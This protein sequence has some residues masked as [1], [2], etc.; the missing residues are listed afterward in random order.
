MRLL[1]SVM[2]SPWFHA[3]L[4]L[5]W[6]AVGAGLRL[7][8]LGSKAPWTDEF[9][10]IVFSLGHSFRTVP[11]D[12]AISLDVLLQPIRF[13][14]TTGIGDVIANLLTQSN[15]PPLYFVLAH[16]WMGLFPPEDGLVSMWVARSLPAL[17]GVLSIP[18]MFG[19]AYLAFRSRLVA[20][21]C[22]AMMAV[23]P[24]GI[25]LAQEA[26][27]Y[28]LAILFVIASLCCLIVTVQRLNHRSSIP[29]W[30]GVS[31]VVINT[32]GVATHYFFALTLCAEALMLLAM[33]WHQG[34]KGRWGAGELGSGGV[35]ERG[36]GGAREQRS[37]GAEERG[38][39]GDGE[40]SLISFPTKTK[41]FHS[42]ALSSKLLLQNQT[43][44]NPQ[45]NSRP[46]RRIY[47]V[48]AGT[49]AGSLVWLPIL[50]ANYDSDLTHWIYDGEPLKRWF[51]P[52]G[53]V[54]AWLITILISLPMEI[55][56]VSLGIAIASGVVTAIFLLWALPLLCS[57]LKLE[58][59]PPDIRLNIRVMRDFII[60]A[61]ALFF[62][63]TYTLGADL[64]LAPRYQFVYFPA[65]IALLGAALATTWNTS[66]DLSYENRH[67][68]T[69]AWG[70]GERIGKPQPSAIQLFKRG[71]KTA[72][73]LIWLMGLL[74]GVTVTWNL[75]YL[76]S[77]RPDFLVK[78]IQNVSNV[79][80]LVA[81]THEHHGHT[82]RMMGLAWEF[83]HLNPFDASDS[84]EMI[85]PQFLLAHADSASQAQDPAITLQKTVAELPRPLDIWL[86]NFHA[87]V[88]L[89]Q[90]NCFAVSQS[91]PKLDSYWYRLYRCPVSE[92][93]G[94]G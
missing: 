38:S 68:D 39:R 53:R 83:K 30:L 47:L 32:L 58:H 67:G 73:I 7:M 72:V 31:W 24:F 85:S 94:N 79:P 90:Q 74:G 64:T 25:F 78:V 23:S 82:G 26:R 14:P 6:I 46:W 18:A 42:I 43:R 44:T 34:K 8:R 57:S 9:A 17:F 1:K 55:S 20:H 52:I 81:T 87:G 36:S 69:G 93:K 50:Q 60:G 29:I 15:H 4:L 76:Q 66:I 5:L 27:H 71:G 16:L 75:G 86:V 63:I 54:L 56:A 11:L 41:A 51:E 28:T 77:I 62:A 61:L 70:H 22:A 13:E 2:G 40:Q 37:G 12:Q 35:G 45:S 65:A 10:T 80:I 49:V 3:L 19:L 92:V 48:V 91:L 88:D 84:K 33:A 59:F 21:S 89:A